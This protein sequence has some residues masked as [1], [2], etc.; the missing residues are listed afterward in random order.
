M[1]LNKDFLARVGIAV[2]AAVL[3]LTFAFYSELNFLVVCGFFV[4]LALREYFALVRRGGYRPMPVLAAGIAGVF[5]FVAYTAPRDDISSLHIALILCVAAMVLLKGA[6]MALQPGRGISPAVFASMFGAL[7]IGGSISCAININHIQRDIFPGMSLGQA[8]LVLLP[9]V[10]AWA[11]D[12]GAYLSGRIVGRERLSRIS[13]NKTREGLMGA[14]AAG[15]TATVI[16]GT[17]LGVHRHVLLLLGLIL[18]FAALAGDLFESAI[19]RRFDAKDSGAFF[20]NHGG[21][22]DRF[23]SIFFCAPIT[24]FLLYYFYIYR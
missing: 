16:F 12:T 21:V 13:P 23:D 20:K 10:G 17:S 6:D 24:Y 8:P 4:A 22:L 15:F 14:V 2:P 11:S 19:K 7:Y 9:F 5:F 3:F 18:P 1:S